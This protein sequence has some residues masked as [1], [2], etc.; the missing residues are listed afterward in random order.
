MYFVTTV[1]A[2][3]ASRAVLRVQI[4]RF[5]SA[6]AAIEGFSESLRGKLLLSLGTS[7]CLLNV[8]TYL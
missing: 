1:T 8:Y 7:G 6:N 2:S 4:V 3:Q 5:R